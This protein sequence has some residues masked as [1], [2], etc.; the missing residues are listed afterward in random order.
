MKQRGFTGTFWSSMSSGSYKMQMNRIKIEKLFGKFDYDIKLNQDE[1][2]TILTGP[3]GYGKTTILNIIADLYA[4][5]YAGKYRQHDLFLGL[6]CFFSDG[7]QLQYNKTKQDNFLNKIFVYLIS[8]Q[9]L[10]QFDKLKQ[11]VERRSPIQKNDFLKMTNK[12]IVDYAEDMAAIISN[13]LNTELQISNAL[14]ATYA[15][16]LF[17][18]KTPLQE[19]EFSR[20]FRQLEQ[21]YQLLLNYGIYKNELKKASYD[22]D[23][24]RP[25]SIYLEDWEKKTAAYDDLI[26]KMEVFLKLLNKK[27][28][29]NKMAA[30]KAGKGFYFVTN[31]DK[32]IP[33]AALSSG[34]QNE[35]IILFELLFRAK[36]ETLALIDEPETSLHVSWQH[37]FLNDLKAIRAVNP[38]SFLIATHSPSIINENWDLTQD[39]SDLTNQFE[40]A[41][42]E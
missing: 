23:N 25:L 21:K 8:D 35:T 5:M 37:D 36:P 1:G 2:I 20:R 38:L 34:E 24:Q 7:Q 22:E 30:I 15:E 39:L 17:E 10:E 28:L 32:E 4:D 16:R 33:L 40:G 31:D 3:N 11:F 14:N 41:S 6:T 26:A 9:R 12:K 18:Y 27:R 42:N 13:A 29:T 19:T